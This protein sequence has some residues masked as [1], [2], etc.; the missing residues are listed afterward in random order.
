MSFAGPHLSTDFSRWTRQAWW[1]AISLVL[2]VMQFRVIMFVQG[3][4]YGS[5]IVAAKGVVLGTP[6]WM[7]YQSRVLGPWTV[8]LLSR[9]NGNFQMAYVLYVIAATAV[10]GWLVLTTVRRL[11]GAEAGWAALFLFHML[12]SALLSQPWLYA[13][14]HYGVIAFILFV[15]FVMDGKDWRWFTA[16]FAVAVFNRESALYIALWMILD[17]L[18][19][20]AMDRAPPKWPMLVSGLACMA[21]GMVVI[22][23]LRQAL[24]VREIGPEMFHAPELAGKSVHIKW[25]QNLDFLNSI[26][27]RF[28]LTF[29]IL[30]PLFLVGIA[31]LA[32]V[33]A[34][35]DP[36]RYLALSATHLALIASIM[37]AA[38]LQ[39]T[40]VM[41]ELVP[42]LCLGIWAARQS[43]DRTDHGRSLP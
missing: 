21:S 4:N 20:A 1:A 23:T 32:V 7:L 34:L 8:E 31:A 18:V 16:L 10:A 14:D 9:L 13:W 5:S 35:R 19:K 29:E 15:R 30:I 17:P 33:L 43:N 37:V 24:L 27:T 22:R 41:L 2:A 42:F 3:S 36:R 26:A 12:F 28:S 25:G 6:H 39:E 11:H 38:V 40:R